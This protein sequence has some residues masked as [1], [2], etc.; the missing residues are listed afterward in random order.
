METL[1]LP[2]KGVLVIPKKTG[3]PEGFGLQERLLPL[4]E[5]L[6]NALGTLAEAEPP[7]NPGA[8]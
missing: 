5:A 2:V 7:S 6:E 8:V 3:L 1:S 4:W